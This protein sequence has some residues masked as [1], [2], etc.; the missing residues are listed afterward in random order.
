MEVKIHCK[1]DALEL[2]AEDNDGEMKGENLTSKERMVNNTKLFKE[3]RLLYAGAYV[4]RKIDG[5]HST[6]SNESTSRCR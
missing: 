1:M 3:S 2:V 5:C 4:W 6:T